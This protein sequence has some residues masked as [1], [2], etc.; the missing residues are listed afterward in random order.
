MAVSSY[1]R[2]NW[3]ILGDKVSLE[4]TSSH[5]VG[6]SVSSSNIMHLHLDHVTI[7]SYVGLAVAMCVR[8]L[9]LNS[10]I[11]TYIITQPALVDLSST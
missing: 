3:S 4:L 9:T 2:H 10:A 5:E 7:I 8:C 6:R 1:G 11:A